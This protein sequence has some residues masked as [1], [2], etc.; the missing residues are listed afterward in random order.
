MHLDLT[1]VLAL[2][3][4][5]LHVKELSAT[6]E[7]DVVA[8]AAPTSRLQLVIFYLASGVWKINSS[9][10]D[11]KYSCASIYA[12][13]LTGHRLSDNESLLRAVALVAPVATIIVELL[14]PLLQAAPSSGR[15]SRLGVAATLVFH[16][17]IG[18]TPP[19]HNIAIYGVTTVTRLFFWLPVSTTEACEQRPLWLVPS[20]FAFAATIMAGVRTREG[21]GNPGLVGALHTDWCLGF[22]ACL[23]CLFARAVYL[24]SQREREISRDR[25]RSSFWRA[26]RLACPM[27]ALAFVYAFLW[28][29]LGLQERGG[30][31]MFSQMRLHGGSN[32][33]LGLPTGLAQRWS[34]GADPT[35]ALTGGVVRVERFWTGGP[36]DFV[37]QGFAEQLPPSTL[38]MLAAAGVPSY[39][40]PVPYYGPGAAG[41]PLVTKAPRFLPHTLSALGLRKL[42]RRAR[43][44]GHPFHITYTRLEHP[45]EGDETWRQTAGRGEMILLEEDP[46]HGT[47]SCRVQNEGS[48]LP[49]LWSRNCEPRE[50]ALLEEPTRH[51]WL[52]HW[53]MPMPNPIIEPNAEMHCVSIS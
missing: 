12:V 53:L 16:F 5:C 34:A 35:S 46:A 45:P 15:W 37:G 14:L 1:M 27:A 6:D 31:L 4:Y 25:V 17:M 33:L 41:L 18:I 51:T 9:F 10:I 3:P 20:M 39:Y 36:I 44:L 47:R 8:M 7:A 48:L 52:T 49:Y 29:M 22:V 38:R 24:E 26:R 30:C 21:H 28:P 50:R 43:A 23:C 32:H 2:L 11:S 40:I 19:P 42:L 13:S